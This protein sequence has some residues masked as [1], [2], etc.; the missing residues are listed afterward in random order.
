MEAFIY[1]FV[2]LNDQGYVERN[3]ENN[4]SRFKCDLFVIWG[5]HPYLLLTV[6]ANRTFK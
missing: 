3:I 6:A 4:D 1:T 2:G 5:Q